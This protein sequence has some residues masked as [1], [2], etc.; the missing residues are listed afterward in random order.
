MKL[1]ATSYVALD[2]RQVVDLDFGAGH[3]CDLDSGGSVIGE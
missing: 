3:E 1:I 2:E